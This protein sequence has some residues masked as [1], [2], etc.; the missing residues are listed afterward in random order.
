MVKNVF[1]SPFKLEKSG[2]YDEDNHRFEAKTA[3]KLQKRNKNHFTPIC[4]EKLF[5]APSK[6]A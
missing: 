6:S 5:H 3:P 1:N 4:H 2:V